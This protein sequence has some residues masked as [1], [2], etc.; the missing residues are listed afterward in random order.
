[1]RLDSYERASEHLYCVEDEMGFAPLFLRRLIQGGREKGCTM[2]VSYDPVHVGEADAL[3][4]CGT[5]IGFVI[6]TRQSCPKAEGYVNMKRFVCWER[7][8]EVRGEYR[9]H[10]KL[11]DALRQQACASFEKAGTHHFALERI[12]GAYM[13]FEKM[14][15]A[16]TSFCK[17][18]LG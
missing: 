18:T 8:R 16:C 13:D 12:Y 11:Y 10:R 5:G 6:G 14:A 2:R 7:M 17:K 3:L 15:D 4:F 1:M 9:M